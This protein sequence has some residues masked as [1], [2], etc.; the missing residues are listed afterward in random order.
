MSPHLATFYDPASEDP[1]AVLNRRF[2]PHFERPCRNPDTII[3]AIEHC[4]IN[5]KCQWRRARE[6]VKQGL[7]TMHSQPWG[8]SIRALAGS[9]TK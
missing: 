9:E 1:M 5:E 3:C 8:S 6:E 2:G 4:R 7:G